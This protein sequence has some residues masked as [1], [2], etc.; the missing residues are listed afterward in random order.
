MYFAAY[1]KKTDVKD[2]YVF[3]I[4][5]GWTYSKGQWPVKNTIGV[6]SKGSRPVNNTVSV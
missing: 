6:Y 1:K 5:S 4:I 3:K 2:L